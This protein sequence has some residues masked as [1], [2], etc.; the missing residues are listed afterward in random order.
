MNAS[1]VP[2]SA[3]PRPDAAGTPGL[4]DAGSTLTPD[5]SSDPPLPQLATGPAAAPAPK[6]IRPSR[7]AVIAMIGV[8]CV[9][10]L[11]ILWAWRLGP[12]ATSVVVTDNAYVR[13]QM[14]VL[15]PQV[16]GY[17][18]EV[19][20]HD[21]ER[22]RAGQVLVRIDDRVYREKVQQAE[23]QLLAA[24]AA[25]D[26]QR[27]TQAQNRATLGA[28][29]AGLQAAEA[30]ARRAAADLARA[31]DLAAKGSVSLRERDQ[32]RVTAELART[33]VARARA[34]IDIGQ[35]TI[36]ATD[37]SRAGLQAQV[38]A[39]QAQL[40]L[41]RIDLA[42]TVVRAPRDG[43]VGE[44]GVR[45]GQYVTAGSQLL[46]LVPDALWVVANFKETQTAHMQV[47]QRATFRVDALEGAELTGRIEQLAPATGSEFSVLRAD[48]ATGNFTKVVQ[49]LPVRI[50]IDP[51]QPL[52][53][54]L[55]PG[56]SLE[57]RVDTTDRGAAPV[58]VP[59]ASGTAQ[60][61][62]AGSAP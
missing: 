42:N 10:V 58:S 31:E 12:F 19:A 25:L 8:A 47:G 55:R 36:R 20:V 27:Q 24:R 17:V 26:N 44:A 22:V 7:A 6:T 9:G 62:S 34:D 40:G 39:A 45:L 13:G 11:L 16:S 5:K 14:T 1:T 53:A 61:A 4:P 52:A 43:Q 46:F 3:A 38:Q 49:R 51:G 50:A 18:A 60:A 29:Q 37:V 41:A 23:A 28:R 15:A 30:E 48:N 21:F 59:A 54:R 56:M 35:Q 57:A 32:A 33:N 2:P